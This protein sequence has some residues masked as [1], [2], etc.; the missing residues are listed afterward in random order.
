MAIHF[1]LTLRLASANNGYVP[2]DLVG[3]ISFFIIPVIQKH[4]KV[5]YSLIYYYS[6]IA[7]FSSKMQLWIKGG[8]CVL[9][10]RIYLLEMGNRSGS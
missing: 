1:T 3:M 9:Q 7:S 4:P 8:N 5:I 10:L 6:E 2:N